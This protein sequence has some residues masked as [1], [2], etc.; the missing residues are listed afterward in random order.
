MNRV[1][2]WAI[3]V[4]ILVALATGGYYALTHRE[5]PPPPP[6]PVATAPALAPGPR[7]PIAEAPAATPLPALNQSD[8]S[9]QESL[10]SLL[11]AQA[12]ERFLNTEGIIRR[13]VATV[14][15]LPREEYSQRLNPVRPMPGVAR[16]T[17]RDSTLALAPENA[18]RYEP[19]IELATRADTSRLVEIYRRHYP[20]F[21]QA[22]VE[23]GYPNGYF[24]DRL[25]EVIDHLLEAPEPPARIALATPHVLYEFADPDLESLSSGQKVMLR[26]GPKGAARLK[27]KLRELR[28]QVAA[29]PR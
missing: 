28:A 2:P 1:L 18:A 19:F 13:I 3:A 7:N 17:G 22:Y 27:E 12:V 24:N 21:Q 6:G 20:L 16:T 14:D 5:P 4:A 25:V 23:L 29:G 26:I 11:G 15:N 10:A 8:A 9:M